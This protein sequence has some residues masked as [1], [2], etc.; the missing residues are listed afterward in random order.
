MIRKS[1]QTIGSTKLLGAVTRATLILA[2][3]SLL[4]TATRPALAQTV[5]TLLT[6]TGSNG[7]NPL[8]GLAADSEG[9]LYGTTTYGGAS[10]VGT[11]FELSPDGEGGWNETV[12]YSFCSDPNC[13]DGEEP[14]FF[15]LIFDSAGNLYGTT[16]A[17]GA[18]E[19][20]TV[21]KLTHVGAVWTETVLHSFDSGLFSP[22][23]N[24]IFDAVGNLYGT[25]RFGGGTGFGGVFELTPSA[26]GWTEQL[27]YDAETV[28]AL[29]TDANENIFGTGPTTVFELSPSESGGWTPTVIHTFTGT[30]TDG[31]LPRGPLVFDQAGNLYGTTVQGGANGDGTVY[32]L[33]PTATGWTEEILYS[34]GDNGADGIWPSGGIVFDA[35]GNIYG[36]TYLGGLYGSDGDI[37]PGTVFELAALPNSSGYKESVLWSFNHTDGAFPDCNFIRGSGGKLYS[38]TYQG[39]S[40]NQGVVFEWNG[41]GLPTTTTLAAS[42][43]PSFNGQAVTFTAT[44]TSATGTPP[45][46]EIVTF[47]NGSAVLGTGV[48]SG[49]IA[50]FITSSFAVGAYSITASYYGDSTFGDSTSASLSQ[51]VK[52]ST[53]SPTSSSLTSTLNPS[54]YGQ[55]VTWTATVTASGPVPPTGKVGFTWG[56]G[57]SLGAAT[58]NASGVATLTRSN[59]N[60]DPYPLIAVYSGDANNLG[61]SSLILNQVVTQTT[62]S[63]T[64][65][66]SPNPS[67]QGEAVTF[68]AKITSPTATPTGP[69]TFTAG[70]T[71]LGT[72]ELTTGK[73]EFTTST[74]PAGTNTITVTYPWNSD[75]AASSASVTQVVQQ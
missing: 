26:G 50:S 37:G 8:S 13:A 35:T 9:N 14:N 18:Y 54:I 71:T 42:P 60:A 21:F 43:N 34:F 73:A 55:K 39:G 59:I 72:V 58:L 28:G 24:L 68:T 30:P 66:A 15:F 1:T 31:D 3:L 17:G 46:G 32:E 4:L 23:G 16:S 62:S 75:I 65:T 10:G 19:L 67:T 56:N 45:N 70:K 38:T 20:G 40:N 41:S 57:Y 47:Y 44:V 49:G 5:T 69:V 61:S 6:F 51:V 27:I 12:L 53:K 33:N 29:I 22:Q 7:A 48:L 52:F 63:A 36:T 74:L 25:T 64:I 2:T 11:I